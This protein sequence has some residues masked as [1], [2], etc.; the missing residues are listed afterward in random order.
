MQMARYNDATLA[1]AL[2]ISF[3][4][5]LNSILLSCS[6]LTLYMQVCYKIECLNAEMTKVYL[7][8]M[9]QF[10][11]SISDH[12]LMAMYAIFRLYHCYIHV[13]W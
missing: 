2:F 12:L 5:L 9:I 1:F 10:T 11:F 6:P 13:P 4:C 8:L 3:A 7:L